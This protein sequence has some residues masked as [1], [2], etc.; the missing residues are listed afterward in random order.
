MGFDTSA[1]AHGARAPWAADPLARLVRQLM[2]SQHRRTGGTF[3]GMDVLILTTTGRK[4]G[5]QRE[6]P[7]AWFPDGPDAWVIVA[8]AGGAART[9]AW[10]RNIAAHPD[11]VR[12]E[13]P[14]RRRTLRVSAEQLGGH[15]R[16]DAWQRIIQAQPRFA[17][18]QEKTG[19]V[20]PVIRLV[21][22]P[23]A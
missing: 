12:I 18:D 3:M 15:R 9:P 14:G 8:S 6:T 5:E 7:V 11:Q 23:G 20:F 22:A 1:G 10:Y 19:R 21:P 2:I 13:L 4:S 16:E 17:K